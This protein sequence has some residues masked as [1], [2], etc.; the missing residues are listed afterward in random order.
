ME[1]LSL[2]ERY[3]N[4]E[5][6]IRVIKEKISAAA[7][8]SGRKPED[9]KLMAVTKTV[10]PMFINHAIDCGIDLIGE[11]KVQEF[12]LKKPYLKLDN[13][14]AHLIGHLQTNKVRQIVGEVNM[15]QSVD[16]V[17]LAKEISK[18]S[19]MAGITTECLVEVN[20]GHEESKTGLDMS[21][22]YETL[23]EIASLPN[24]RIKGLM[25]IPPICDDEDELNKYFSK[26]NEIFIDIKDKK[27]DNID[28]CILSMGMSSDYEEAILCGSNL[29]IVGSAIFGPR[30]Y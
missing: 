1:T 2:D 3:K 24:I 8:A 4:I 28:M 13:C 25:T 6:N 16:S 29:V 20:I 26:M 27:L 22:L 19:E 14:K 12:L 21:L 7:I 17:R 30:I 9:V 11:N 23:N 10:E 15:I 18:R 5:H